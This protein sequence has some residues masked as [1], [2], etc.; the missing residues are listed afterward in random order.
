MHFLDIPLKLINPKMFIYVNSR[1][2]A[3]SEIIYEKII[4]AAYCFYI[5]SQILLKFPTNKRGRKEQNKG[6]KI[7]QILEI[8]F[9]MVLKNSNRFLLPFTCVFFQSFCQNLLL[10]A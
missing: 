3:N 7:M 8:G 9:S 1:N 4:K 6:R 10:F 2:R 5:K